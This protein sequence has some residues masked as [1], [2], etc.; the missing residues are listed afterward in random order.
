MAGG[1]DGAEEVVRNIRSADV[2]GNF[3]IYPGKGFSGLR[4]DATVLERIL[5]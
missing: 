2:P 3:K 1:T 4:D 5:E